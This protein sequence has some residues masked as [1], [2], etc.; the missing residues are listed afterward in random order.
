MLQSPEYIK[1]GPSHSQIA[2]DHADSPFF[3]TAVVLAGL[4]DQQ[5]R[6]KM[7]DVWASEGDKN[8]QKDDKLKQNYAAEIPPEIAAR[9]PPPGTPENQMTQD[10]RLAIREAQKKAPHFKEFKRRQEGETMLKEGAIPEGE[11]EHGGEAAYNGIVTGIRLLSKEILALPTTMRKLATRMET[12]APDIAATLTQV[13][14]ELPKGIEQLADEIEAAQSAD[15]I[16]KLA[17][18]LRKL[19]QEKAGLISRAQTVL[20][21]AASLADKADPAMD[22]LASAIRVLA[23]QLEPITPLITEQLTKAADFLGKRG[24]LKLRSEQQ[25][26]QVHTMAPV[27]TGTWDAE[28]SKSAGRAQAG[29]AMSPQ[30]KALFDFVHQIMNHPY[31][32]TWWQ[33]PLLNWC[34]QNKARLEAYIRARNSGDMHHHDH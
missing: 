2:K 23:K 9:L 33:E 30:R 5:M 16:S 32:S 28:F 7:I 17:A 22:D 29:Q 14:D 15:A 13:A 26:Q 12:L 31:E 18:K 19:A 6:D 25:I 21:R 20:R 10:Q 27:Q 11:E 4:I 3:G 24:E 1:A 8:T 34:N